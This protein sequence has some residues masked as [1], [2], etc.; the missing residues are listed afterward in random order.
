M[1]DRERDY[2]IAY[3][4]ATKWL[5]DRGLKFTPGL[6]RALARAMINAVDKARAKRQQEH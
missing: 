4:A 5:N 3:D 6:I 1:I 2:R